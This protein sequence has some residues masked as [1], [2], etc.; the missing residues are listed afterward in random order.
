M[1]GKSIGIFVLYCFI[2]LRSQHSGGRPKWISVFEPNLVYR[3][4]VRT[5]KAT[6]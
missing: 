1:Y 5:T 4:S 3:V 6:Q 2:S